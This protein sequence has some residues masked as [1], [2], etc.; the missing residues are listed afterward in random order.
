MEKWK[1]KLFFGAKYKLFLQFKGSKASSIG[2]TTLVCAKQEKLNSACG[3]VY[4]AS[5][6][7]K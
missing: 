3:W 1:F 6:N 7:K 5:Q 2:P 4:F